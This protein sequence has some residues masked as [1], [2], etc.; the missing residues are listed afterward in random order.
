MHSAMLKTHWSK[1]FSHRC[2][3]KPRYSHCMYNKCDGRITSRT[4]ILKQSLNLKRLPATKGHSKLICRQENAQSRFRESFKKRLN[5]IY[6]SFRLA[7]Y[8][9]AHIVDYNLFRSIY[10][11]DIKKFLPPSW[12]FPKDEL[13]FCLGCGEIF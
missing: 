3:S 11:E 13:L 6:G 12:I 5:R 1:G 7:L 10:Q 2:K 9:S 8:I 4:G